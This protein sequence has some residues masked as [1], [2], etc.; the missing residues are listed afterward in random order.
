MNDLNRVGRQSIDQ[1]RREI[2][3][4]VEEWLETPMLV[5]SFV[6]TALL[7]LEFVE[8]LNPLLNS[9]SITIWIVFILDFVLRLLLA[10]Q[11]L[12]YLKHNWLSATA[13][14]LPAL[15]IFHTARIIRVLGIAPGMQGIQLLRVLARINRGMKTLSRSVSRRGFGYAIV[16][17]LFIV[18]IGAAGMYEFERNITGSTL[19]NYGNALW[20]TAMIMTTMG[21]DYFPKTPEGRMLCFLLALYAFA[22]FGYVTAT[23][24]TFFV[25]QDAS[26]DDSEIA[27]EKSIKALQ[28][29][30]AALRQEIQS[31]P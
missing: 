29:E 9:V 16:L 11:R 26:D 3:Q 23:I 18:M 6:W 10:P 4:Q 15:W 13:L 12:N 21:S 30:I 14:L 31:R 2:L 27:S 24:A 5:L 7:I 20:W 8:G 25:G 19:T 1:E 28:A 22:V 17:T